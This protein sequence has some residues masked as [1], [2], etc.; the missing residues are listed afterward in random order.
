MH[1]EADPERLTV[2][3]IKVTS[4]GMKYL[5]WGRSTTD[6]IVAES[7]EISHD[8]GMRVWP[9]FLKKRFTHQGEVKEFTKHPGNIIV[10]PDGSKY[11]LWFDNPEHKY[12]IIETEALLLPEIR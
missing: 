8:S 2:G 3:L 7:E 4:F 10:K 9:I 5:H 6:Y 11:V 12:L 1:P